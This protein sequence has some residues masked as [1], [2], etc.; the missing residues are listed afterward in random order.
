MEEPHQ[1]RPCFLL[2]GQIWTPESWSLKLVHHPQERIS[3]VAIPTSALLELTAATEGHVG[4]DQK[5][6]RQKQPITDQTRG[7]QPKPR[8]NG[9]PVFHDS[10]L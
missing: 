5:A 3:A 8:H 6:R 7:L 1:K 10:A 2:P 9:G 4:A